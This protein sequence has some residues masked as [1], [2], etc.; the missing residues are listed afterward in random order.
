[1][2][3]K[4]KEFLK[5]YLE[6]L[7]KLDQALDKS[8]LINIAQKIVATAESN[9]T[10]IIVGNGGSA[11]IASHATIDFLKAVGIRAMNF[12]ESSLLTCYSNDYGYENWVKEALKSYV[13]IN[14]SVILISSSGESAN[15]INAAH[16]VNY[17][18]LNLITFTGFKKDNSLSKLGDTNIWVDSSNYNYVEITHNKFLLILVDLVKFILKK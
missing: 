13:Q 16:Y 15:I 18:K 12:N 11:A 3:N 1:M 10:V 14:D 6:D 8:L 5:S 7:H 2:M 4:N 17:R 9:G